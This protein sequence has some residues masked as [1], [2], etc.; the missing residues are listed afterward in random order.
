MADTKKHYGATQYEWEHFTC[1]LGLTEDLLPVVSNPLA[2]KTPKSKVT[3]FSKVPSDYNQQNLARGWPDWP[4]YKATDA[5]V[6]KWL[7]QS[8]YGICL[9]TR[10]VRAFDIDVPDKDLAGAISKVIRKHVVLPVRWREGT[11]KC[12][13]PFEMAGDN[14]PRRKIFVKGGIVEFLGRDNH[15]VVSGT[16]KSGNRYQWFDIV[17]GQRAVTGLPET[18]PVIS[19]ELFEIIWKELI[20]TFAITPP[21]KEGK[22]SSGRLTGEDD[23]AAMRGDPIASFL[24]SDGRVLSHNSNGSLNL[25]C[26]W[27]DQ[28]TTDNGETQTTYFPEGS[29]GY[30]SGNFVCLHA[31]C[32]DRK[33]EDYLNAMHYYLDQF[34]NVSTPEDA[35]KEE[36]KRQRLQFMKVTQFARRKR[37]PWLIK[38]VLPRGETMTFGASGSGKTFAILDMVCHL[39][40]GIDWNGHKTKRSR[41]AY[42]CAEGAGGFISRIQA[43]AKKYDKLLTDLDDWLIITPD[44]PNFLKEEDARLTADRINEHFKGT[45][46]FIVIDTLAQ[47][48][49]GADEN[50]AKDMGLAL[51]HAKLLGVLTGAGYNLVHHTGKDED[52]G[53]RGSSI[54]KGQLDAMFYI[55]RKDDKRTFWIEKM[56][57]GKDQFGYEFDLENLEVGTDEDGDPV[58]SCAVQYAGV[59]NGKKAKKVLK[60]G[61]WQQAVMTAWLAVGGGNVMQKE[62]FDEV[63][64][65]SVEPDKGKDDRRPEQIK[66][67]L[68]SLAQ[69]GVFRLDNGAILIEDIDV[70][71]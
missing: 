4:R 39:V 35:A 43:W 6:R 20:D 7:K 51:R 54:I 30:K 57:D 61:R 3:D 33:K 53:A 59:S 68:E 49:A 58:V 50:S 23:E 2:Q 45:C 21:A 10:K 28:H 65:T 60:R 15:F 34:E 8:D 19:T 42:V 48:T 1:V 18:I 66:R 56:K 47:V 22:V 24:E 9:Q 67:A 52:K 63:M 62:V 55:F 46:D 70:T 64:R 13:H 16:H 31:H 41:C 37:L 40:L 26:P 17:E 44:T 29:R 71:E 11:G 25:D 38:G 36:T 12:L 27:K 32:T 5:D 69:E 14:Y